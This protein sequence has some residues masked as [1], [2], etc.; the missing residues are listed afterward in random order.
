MTYTAFYQG[1]RPTSANIVSGA[2]ELK[3]LLISH[4]QASVQTITLYDSL[5]ATGT[6]LMQ[7]YLAPGQCPFLLWLPRSETL[8]FANG[9]SYSATNCELSVWAMKD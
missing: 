4:N 2:G 6:I 5:T 8:H 3:G 9:L 1:I 7:I